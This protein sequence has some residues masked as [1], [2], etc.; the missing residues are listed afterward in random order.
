MLGLKL[1]H[2]SKRGHKGPIINVPALDSDD[3]LAPNRQQPII[4]SNRS[5]VYWRMYASLGLD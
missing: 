1:N 2:V 3:D 4:W 5:P